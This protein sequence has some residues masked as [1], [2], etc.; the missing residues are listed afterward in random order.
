[1]IAS[2][3]TMKQL[4]MSIQCTRQMKQFLA[5]VTSVRRRDDS[6]CVN[7]H[8]VNIEVFLTLVC[9]MAIRTLETIGQIVST[10]VLP[11][12]LLRCKQLAALVTL[13]WKVTRMVA[14]DVSLQGT[15]LST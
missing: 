3:L 4:Y 7:V 10:A 8:H 15:A 11:R 6:L 9:F 5:P 1:M 13:E 2:T 12:L 14:N